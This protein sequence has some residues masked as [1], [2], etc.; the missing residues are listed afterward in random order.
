[1]AVE[2]IIEWEGV[3]APSYARRFRRAAGGLNDFT[4]ALRDIATLAIA[5]AITR[6]FAEG[7][8]PS[9]PPLDDET[10]KRKIRYGYFSPQKIL[11]ATGAMMESATDPTQY[12]ITPLS[13]V[14]EPAPDY[15]I[16]HQVGT[17]HVPQRVMMNLAVADQRKIG[18]IFDRFIA[19][20]LQK[21]GLRVTGNQ[22]V[23]GGSARN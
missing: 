7:G 1:M 4:P 23:V 18:G 13:I 21:A 16:Y 20:E 22:T 3:G 5:P 14:A 2:L 9:W 17:G 12:Q 6:N 10:I 11:V 15:W 19:K 8:R